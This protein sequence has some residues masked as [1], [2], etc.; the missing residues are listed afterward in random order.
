MAKVSSLKGTGRCSLTSHPGQK[1]RHIAGDYSGNRRAFLSAARVPGT[2]SGRKA[3]SRLREECAKVGREQ[4][5]SQVGGE[6]PVVWCGCS[7][8][9]VEVVWEPGLR[10]VAKGSEAMYLVT[11]R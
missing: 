7:T 3:Q 2:A 1:T 4:T 8:D 5:A 11:P 9:S 10:K 6:A